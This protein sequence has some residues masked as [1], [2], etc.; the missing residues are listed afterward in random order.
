MHCIAQWL[1]HRAKGSMH[2]IVKWVRG[3]EGACIVQA[4]HAALCR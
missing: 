4:S 1:R 3:Q 2:C